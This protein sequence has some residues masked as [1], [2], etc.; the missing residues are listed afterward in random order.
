MPLVRGL[1]VLSAVS[2]FTFLCLCF[3]SSK[4]DAKQREERQQY[5]HDL[6]SNTDKKSFTFTK[7]V[8][9]FLFQ[10]EKLF[11]YQAFFVSNVVFVRDNCNHE[12]QRI[13]EKQ[14]SDI[15]LVL[16]KYNFLNILH[17]YKMQKITLKEAKN[18]LSANFG[19]KENDI[20]S[21]LNSV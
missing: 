6:P 1:F 8:L 16:K 13:E 5:F 2:G 17:K 11:L 15:I 14:L 9:H 4:K 20:L 19:L 7:N 21:I 18:L 10:K 3:F 12:K